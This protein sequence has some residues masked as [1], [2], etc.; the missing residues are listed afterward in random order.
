MKPECV[1]DIDQLVLNLVQNKS[2]PVDSDYN[3]VRQW[4][5]L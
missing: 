1:M 2:D 5:M 3:R 4:S